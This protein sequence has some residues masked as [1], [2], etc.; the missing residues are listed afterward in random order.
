MERSIQTMKKYVNDYSDNYNTQKL[1][2]EVSDSKQNI[3]K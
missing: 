2:K 3:L 1:Q